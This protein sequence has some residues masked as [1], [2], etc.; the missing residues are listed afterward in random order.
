MAN[1][2]QGMLDM[3]IL[4]RHFAIITTIAVCVNLYIALEKNEEQKYEANEMAKAE[5]EGYEVYFA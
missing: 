1:K 4:R 2:I 5:E 3:L